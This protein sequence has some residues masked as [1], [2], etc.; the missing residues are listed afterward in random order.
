MRQKVYFCDFYLNLRAEIC[1]P[2]NEHLGYF[3]RRIDSPISG[4]DI[5]DP[6]KCFPYP[7]SGKIGF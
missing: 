5:S 2:K 1:F 4:N 7:D 3:T 6:L